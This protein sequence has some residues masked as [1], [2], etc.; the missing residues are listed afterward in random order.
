M[1]F[2][3]DLCHG[4][5]CELEKEEPNESNESKLNDSK[6]NESKQK[7][8]IHIDNNVIISQPIDIPFTPS[9]INYLE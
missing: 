6:P 8:S 9:E 1:E 5:F 4:S 2:S 3:F 7:E